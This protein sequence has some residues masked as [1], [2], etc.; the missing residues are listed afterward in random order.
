MKMSLEFW[1][2]AETF[3]E[4]SLPV[5]GIGLGV[6]LLIFLY[7]RMYAKGKV[8]TIITFSSL[9][10]FLALG[11]YSLWGYQHYADY[12]PKAKIVTPLIRDREKGLLGYKE[13][14]W[15]ELRT[16]KRFNDAEDIRKLDFYDETEV[17]EEVTYLGK[18]SYFHYF[19][20][21]NEKIFKIEKNVTFDQ[22]TTVPSMVGVTFH[23]NKP[24]YKQ[25]GFF[26]PERI[27]YE[28][29]MIPQKEQGKTFEPD[30]DP[31]VPLAK[32]HFHKWSF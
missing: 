27:M 11:G 30:Y 15:D 17:S 4:A 7:A 1:K 21:Q 31:H 25:I 3:Y 28:R 16:Y 19:E 26:D 5:A 14:S 6:L 32:D 20:D 8:K 23:I 12:L 24:E 2:T 9:L 10:F 22:K 18:G 29:V 13:Y